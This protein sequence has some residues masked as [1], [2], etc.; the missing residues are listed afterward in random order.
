MKTTCFILLPLLSLSS[1]AN[2]FQNLHPTPRLSTKIFSAKSPSP[3]PPNFENLKDVLNDKIASLPGIM[4]GIPL[5][6]ISSYYTYQHYGENIITLKIATLELLLGFY[7]YGKDRLNDAVAFEKDVLNNKFGVMS[8]TA[9]SAELM[10]NKKETYKNILQNK[11]YYGDLYTNIYYLFVVI[12]LNTNGANI[13]DSIICLALYQI[14]K[15]LIKFPVDFKPIIYFSAIL[16]TAMHQFDILQYLPFLLLLDVT[17]NYIQIKKIKSAGLFKSVF[18]ASMWVTAVL[19]LPA[20]IHDG[21]Y[22]ILN[23][24]K[25]I[26]SPFLLMFSLTNLADIPDVEIDK[27][28]GIETIP[29]KY[30]TQTTYLICGFNAAVYYLLNK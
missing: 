21:D 10:T 6:I 27:Y 4:V 25:D 15:V 28:N 19:I 20:V 12:L 16:L 17:D 5:N 2:G 14:T 8:A 13:I 9:A 23:S 29:A 1:L 11:G 22:S 30:G 7:T 18:V 26:L 3:L 24:P